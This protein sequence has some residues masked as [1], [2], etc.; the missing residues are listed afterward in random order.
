ML[1]QALAD[2][3]LLLHFGFIVF[4]LFGGILSMW[5]RWIPWIHLPAVF[6]A[7]ALEFSGWIC[8]L[9][10]LENRLRQWGGES[11]YAGGFIEQY[12]LAIIYP[13]GLTQEIQFVL[14]AIVVLMTLVT[15][16]VVWWRRASI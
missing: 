16:G 11:G 9:T 8:P 7:A 4:V 5:W 10:P 1:W 14:G 15:Y 13:Q 3:V 2:L 12:A 6:W